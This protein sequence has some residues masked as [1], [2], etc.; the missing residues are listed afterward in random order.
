MYG[1]INDGYYTLDDFYTVPFSNALYPQYNTQYILKPGVVTNA[2]IL[3]NPLQ[4]GSPKYKDLNKDGKVDADNDRTIIGRAQPKFF[5]GLNQTFTYKGFELSVFA[6][7]VVGN[8]VFNANKLEFAN[9]YGSQV[10]MLT[11]NNSRWRMIDDKGNSIQ[12]VVTI[13]G[14]SYIVGIDSAKLRAANANAKIWLPSTSV[15]GFYSQSYAVEDGSYLR[16]N[17]VTLAYNFPKRW[18]S[19]AKMSN[20]RLYVTVNNLA[21]IT[22]YSGFDPDANTRRSDPTTP[23]VD[24]AA[25]PRARTYVAG[26]NVTF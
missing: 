24:Y 12:R 19:K 14:T 16:I 6:N 22:G 11:V 18:I 13:A 23:G 26:V 20:L 7:F 5:G 3:A 4:P 2:T 1:Y 8:D 25:Y 15:N 10:N 9:A 17:N 21:M